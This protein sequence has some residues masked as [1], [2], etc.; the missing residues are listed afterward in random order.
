[1]VIGV[2]PNPIKGPKRLGG[3]RTSEGG[4]LWP[5]TTFAGETVL[6]PCRGV[7]S[8]GGRGRFERRA[9]DAR[10]PTQGRACCSHMLLGIQSQSLCFSF[11]RLTIDLWLNLRHVCM[12]VFFGSV[13]RILARSFR[14]GQSYLRM[15]NISYCQWLSAAFATKAQG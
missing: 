11:R 5:L 8:R 15:I 13:T 2:I 1:M 14:W 9:V 10:A 12:Y 6:R 4:Q 7:F 3:G